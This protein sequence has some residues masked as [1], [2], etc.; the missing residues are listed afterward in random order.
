MYMYR[1]QELWEY[2]QS[3]MHMYRGQECTGRMHRAQCTCTED[4]NALGACTEYNVHVQRT[5]MYG[6]HAQSTMYMYR[7]QECTRR[8]H[9]VQCTDTED[10][11]V[12]GACTRY[13]EHLK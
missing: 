13:R 1:G 2:A 6:G 10:S 3:I 11:N 5:G 12:P 7:G 8:M 4:R 9:R